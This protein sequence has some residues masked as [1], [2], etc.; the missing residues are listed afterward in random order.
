[1][2]GARRLPQLPADLR[3]CGARTTTAS[4]PGPRLRRPRPQ[5]EPRGRSGLPPAGR[6]TPFSPWP[7]TSCAARLRQ[8]GRPATAPASNWLSIDQARPLRRGAGIWNGRHRERRRTGFVLACAVTSHPGSAGRRP[9]AAPA[10]ARR[11]SVCERGRHDEAHAPRMTPA[12]HDDFD[13]T[14]LHRDKPVIFAYHG[15]RWLIHRLA[16]RRVPR[17]LHTCA[18]TGVRTT[19]TPF[20]MVVRNDPRRYRLVMDVIDRSPPRRAAPRTPDDGRRPHPPPR[21]DP[22]HGHRPAESRTGPG[23]PDDRKSLRCKSSRS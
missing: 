21:L 16:Y 9:V 12:R 17:E 10:S 6:Q 7:I 19:T 2:A 3:T 23:T 20:D 11:A 1:V 8:R 4:R 13:T 18:A 14:A 15:Y 5:Q 22:R